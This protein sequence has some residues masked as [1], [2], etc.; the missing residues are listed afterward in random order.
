MVIAFGLTQHSHSYAHH[1]TGMVASAPINLGGG[2][3]GESNL[4]L[5]TELHTSAT[6]E[7]CSHRLSRPT[8]DPSDLGSIAGR[9]A[10]QRIQIHAEREQ[11]LREREAK[12]IAKEKELNDAIQS[13]SVTTMV[14]KV[15][16]VRQA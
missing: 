9:N 1:D 7:S 14:E 15:Q 10:A 4:L 5:L 12:L 2:S 6:W 16:Q 13:S 11:Q 8:T 3:N